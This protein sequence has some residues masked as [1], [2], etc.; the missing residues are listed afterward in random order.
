MSEKRSAPED[1]TFVAEAIDLRVEEDSPLPVWMGRAIAVDLR[2]AADTI[3][4]LRELVREL[5]DEAI[6]A[7]VIIS[8][9][10]PHDYSAL[11]PLQD[12]I[13]KANKEL[14]DVNSGAP[15]GSGSA[16]E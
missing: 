6:D 1:L 16:H 3:A 15:S 2:R 4:D 10:V 13:A 14:G 7:V 9:H 12:A 8:P 5:R 11:A